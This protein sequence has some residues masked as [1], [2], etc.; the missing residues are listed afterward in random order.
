MIILTEVYVKDM[1]MRTLQPVN[2][3]KTIWVNPSHIVLMDEK[4][5]SMTLSTEKIYYFR[6]HAKWEYIRTMVYNYT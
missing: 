1:D 5:L 2:K 4:E 6:H 3:D